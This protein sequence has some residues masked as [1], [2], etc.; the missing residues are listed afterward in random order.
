M[1]W[2]NCINIFSNLIAVRCSC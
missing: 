1:Q 2:I